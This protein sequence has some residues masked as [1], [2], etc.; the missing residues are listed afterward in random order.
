MQVVRMFSNGVADAKEIFHHDNVTT[1][2]L[3]PADLTDLD[4]DL[5]LG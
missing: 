5:G 1:L 4:L 3:V 2:H